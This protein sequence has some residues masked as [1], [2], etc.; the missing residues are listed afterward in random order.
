MK[1]FTITVSYVVN[2]RDRDEAVEIAKSVVSDI[3]DYAT[4]FKLRDVETGR[5]E[6]TG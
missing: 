2:A 6:E 3:V 5:I 1:E 4:E